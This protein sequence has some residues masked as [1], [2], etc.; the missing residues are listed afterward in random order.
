MVIFDK[1]EFKILREIDW[2]KSKGISKA[3]LESKF[4]TYLLGKYLNHLIELE[5]IELKDEKYFI[6]AK[7]RNEIDENDS[8]FMHRF[9][10][11]GLTIFAIY[12]AF[13]AIIFAK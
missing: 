10:T 1:T 8:K 9:I 5:F 12:V 11:I 7:G 3:G 2:S 13:L 6:T 4:E